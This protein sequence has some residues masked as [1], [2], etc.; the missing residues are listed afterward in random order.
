MI[1]SNGTDNV[2]IIIP[3]EMF[4]FIQDFSITAD[5]CIYKD[6]KTTIKCMEWSVM[7]YYREYIFPIITV[8]NYCNYVR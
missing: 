6:R 7:T 4:H 8:I 2:P 3:H 1:M 5:L